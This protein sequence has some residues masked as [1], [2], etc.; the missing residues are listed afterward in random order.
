MARPRRRKQVVFENANT[1]QHDLIAWLDAQ[2][3]KPFSRVAPIDET[4]EAFDPLHRRRGADDFAIPAR[5][6][7]I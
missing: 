2:E 7:E 4:I 6:E 1:N 5:I 3:Q